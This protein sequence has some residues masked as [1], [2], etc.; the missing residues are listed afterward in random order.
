M[1]KL[2]NL[3]IVIALMLTSCG[4]NSNKEKD[5]N[6]VTFDLT[7]LINNKKTEEK[8]EVIT[9]AMFPPA[10]AA[11]SSLAEPLEVN[12]RSAA[13]RW[14]KA[15]KEFNYKSSIAT[16]Q[17]MFFIAYAL[18]N[19]GDFMDKSINASGNKDYKECIN[20]GLPLEVAS[21]CYLKSFKEKVMHR[22][23]A[24]KDLQETAY[25]WVLPEWKKA[26]A[27]M[28]NDR[29]N[30]IKNILNHMISYTNNYNYKKELDFYNQCQG[31]KEYLF[32]STY[33]I[34][35]DEVNYENDIKNPYRKT[36]AWVFRR[37]HAKHLTAT[38]INIWLKKINTDLGF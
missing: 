9:D 15:I 16:E 19:L 11:I 8:E 28:D 4:G 38:E 1:K 18:F 23:Y 36:E 27:N 7:E 3:L 29:K 22:I 21:N 25:N 13:Y 14:I 17:P 10:P 32:T 33:P 26:L 30:L 24:S 2:Q 5:N 35:N 20:K 34:V 12:M 31:K 37:V 6:A